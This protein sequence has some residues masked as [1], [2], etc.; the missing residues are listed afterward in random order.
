MNYLENYYSNYDEEGRLLS[1]H[2]QVEFRTTMKYIY[3]VA[4]EIKAHKILEVG[5]GTGR[6]SI[7]LVLILWMKK[8]LIYGCNIIFPFVR[9]W[10]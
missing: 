1:N 6:Y 7:A 9:E 8:H 2:G 5:A 4:N 3:E 10:I